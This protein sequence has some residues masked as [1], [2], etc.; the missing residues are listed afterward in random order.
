MK[1]R[2][3]SLSLL[4][5]ALGAGQFAL[6]GCSSGDAAKTDDTDEINSGQRCSGGKN[7]LPP[8]IEP[9][10]VLRG[11]YQVTYGPGT[12]WLAAGGGCQEIAN[13]QAKEACEKNDFS[14]TEKNWGPNNAEKERLRLQI[15]TGPHSWFM[16]DSDD[17][18]YCPP[19]PA[20]G[21]SSMLY[22][23]SDVH[24]I[25]PM[26]G[27]VQGTPIDPASVS[28]WCEPGSIDEASSRC[29]LKAGVKIDVLTFEIAPMPGEECFNG[30]SVPEYSTACFGNLIC[31]NGVWTEKSCAARASSSKSACSRNGYCESFVT[32]PAEDAPCQDPAGTPAGYEGCASAL[33]GPGGAAEEY[34]CAKDGFWQKKSCGE[35]HSTSRVSCGQAG[36][37]ESH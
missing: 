9:D 11:K 13:Q 22:L 33:S 17:Y 16:I 8:Y 14:A 19:D 6:A 35:V 26:E 37:C 2:T 12:R 18:S 5:L 7:W 34:T 25:I 1:L 24:V 32:F 31:D 10:Y 3:I 36:Y 23:R 20:S 30:P 15:A 27:R 4:A 28:D 21:K 29:L